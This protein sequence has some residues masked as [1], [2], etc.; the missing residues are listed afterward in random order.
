MVKIRLQMLGRRNRASF[1]IVVTDSRVKRQGLYL[2][3]LGQYDPILA[4][5]AKQV[6]LNVER[7]QHWIGQGAQA[8][9]AVAIL[10]RK[11]GVKVAKAKKAKKAAPKT[12]AAKA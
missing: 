10:L 9:G 6:T 2:E 11:A 3:K 4:D 1:R 7:A 12:E 8:T 5:E